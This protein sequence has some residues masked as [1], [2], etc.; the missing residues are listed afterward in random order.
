[1]TTKNTSVVK[2]N[3]KI[4]TFRIFICFEFEIRDLEVGQSC[5]TDTLGNS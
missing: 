3:N 1:M 5:L 4:S 2:L